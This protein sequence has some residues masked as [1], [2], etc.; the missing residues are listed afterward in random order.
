MIKVGAW[1]VRVCGIS[2]RLRDTHSDRS[3]WMPCQTTEISA[4]YRQYSGEVSASS[5]QARSAKS[6]SDVFGIVFMIFRVSGGTSGY[7]DTLS[8]V[9]RSVRS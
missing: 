2:S 9:F 4:G 6:Q 3:S 7:V 1:L 8:I 5:D